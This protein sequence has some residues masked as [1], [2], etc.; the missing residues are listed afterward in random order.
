MRR[1]LP[2]GYELDDDAS[3]IDLD[4]VC[5][6]L[7]TEYWSSHRTREEQERLVRAST[8]V[9][10]L[11]G[12]DG[13]QVGFCRVVSDGGGFAWLGDVFV[14]PD[15]RRRGLGEELVRE[16]VEHPPHR[17]LTW[18]LGTRDA[19]DLY[20]NLGFTRHDPRTMTRPGSR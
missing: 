18:Y 10:G 16:A 11:Y 17:D 12:P 5:G 15:H 4:V 3:L 7:V 6:Y 20:R 8:R 13:T 19:Q 1:V 9:I 14:L 2:G